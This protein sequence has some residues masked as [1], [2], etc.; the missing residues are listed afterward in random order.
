MGRKTKSRTITKEEVI[1]YLSRLVRLETVF[2]KEETEILRQAASLL[3][4][5]DVALGETKTCCK[6]GTLYPANMKFFDHDERNDGGLCH[7]CKKCRRTYRRRRNE[8]NAI[9]KM[10]ACSA[11][12][13]EINRHRAMMG[14]EPLPTGIKHR[15]GDIV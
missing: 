13:A 3:L 6:C 12:R 4:N 9:S 15:N 11:D 10:Y 14:K 7:Q 5:T 1:S 8:N 2:P